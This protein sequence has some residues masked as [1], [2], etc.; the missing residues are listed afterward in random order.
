MKAQ[1]R[2]SRVQLTERDIARVE[3]RLG[4]SLPLQYREF[5]RSHNG[6]RPKPDA[7]PIADN[8]S[9]DHGLVDYFLCIKD[10]DV[11]NLADWV[12][13]FQNRVPPDL[14]PI[15]VDPGGNLICLAIAGQNTGKVYFWDH[16][17]EVTEGET[18]RYDNVYFVTN[19]F[20]DFVD[21]LAEL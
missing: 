8:A 11:Y 5:L 9:D 18:P 3:M 20:K 17:N 19:S 2:R 16:E 7:F 1:I 15:A 21:S 12:T 10:D 6:G 4:I 14:L 13:D